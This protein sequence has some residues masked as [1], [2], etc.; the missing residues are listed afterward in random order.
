MNPD[1]FRRLVDLN[2]QFYDQF[3]RSFTATR[4]GPLA[5][6]DRLLDT[7]PDQAAVL[8]VGCG[9]GQL[10]LALDRLRK[11][12]R[13]LGVD[14]SPQMLACAQEATRDLRHVTAEFVLADVTEPGWLERLPH[15]AFDVVALLAVLHHI[16]D[17]VVRRRLLRQLAGLLTEAGV[18]WVTTW[19]FLNSER[20]RARVQP[21][22]LI[23]LSEQDVDPG[24]YLLDWRRD[25]YGLRYCALIGEPA[26]RDLAWQAGLR[27]VEIYVA[28]R[29]GLNLCAVLRP[30]GSA[31]LPRSS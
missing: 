10:A 14:V 12:V 26:L 16:P 31:D 29:E 15:R 6:V 25:G 27:P 4:P 21:W 1:V 3:A 30:A 9:G 7:V 28:G 11:P 23:G 22:S 17:V 2:R 8:D 5:G 18:I 19:Q 24:D 20:L 13:Y